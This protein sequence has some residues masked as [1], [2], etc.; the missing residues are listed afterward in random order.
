M[1]G[2]EEFP[3][4]HSLWRRHQVELSRRKLAEN[5]WSSGEMGCGHPRDGA[6]WEEQRW[7]DSPPGPSSSVQLL[8]SFSEEAPPPSS[9]GASFFLIVRSKAAGLL[10]FFYII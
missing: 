2:N 5:I 8:S 3:S 6:E 7:G 1:Q 4:R 10:T 9:S